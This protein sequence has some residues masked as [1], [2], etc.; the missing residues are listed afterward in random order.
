MRGFRTK[1]RLV[2]D[3]SSIWLFSQATRNVL[4]ESLDLYIRRV[5]I[6]EEL[7]RLVF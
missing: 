1:C 2:F 5:Q 4:T 7:D 3:V 6:L